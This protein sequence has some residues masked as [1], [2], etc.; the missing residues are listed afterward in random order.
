MFPLES[1]YRRFPPQRACRV[2][3]ST[4]AG[5]T[6]EEQGQGLPDTYFTGV[7]RDAMCVDYGEPAGV[8]IGSRDGS[9]YA[10]PDEGA[11]WVPVIEHLPDV[12]CL[13]A[14]TV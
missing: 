3:R 13:R 4:D 10:S 1:S 8:Y 7:M 6:W 12:L 9:V 2:W 11:G 14:A 5:A